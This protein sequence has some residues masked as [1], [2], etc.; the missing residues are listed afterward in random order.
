MLEKIFCV[1]L[2]MSSISLCQSRTAQKNTISLPEKKENFNIIK[3]EETNYNE[4]II[5]TT[6]LKCGDKIFVLM[7]EYEDDNSKS[8]N[9]KEGDTIIKKIKLPGQSDVNG[10]S[11][12]WARETKEGFEISIEYGSRIYYQKEFSFICKQNNFYLSKLKIIT[13]DKHNPETSGEAINKIIK[14][15]LP[16]EKFLISDFLVD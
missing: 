15:E 13:F 11:L 6:N 2:L 7:V 3:K 10:F 14:P 8:I 12:N 5:S 16:V 1:F 4:D 9:I